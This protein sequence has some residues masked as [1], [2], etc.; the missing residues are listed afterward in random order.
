LG[1]Q[2][3]KQSLG[4]AVKVLGREGPIALVTCGWQEREDQDEELPALLGRPN[5]ERLHSTARGGPAEGYGRK[6]F[7]TT[8]AS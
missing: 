8:P 3:L 6:A 2:Q 7:T 4:A 5:A 1:P